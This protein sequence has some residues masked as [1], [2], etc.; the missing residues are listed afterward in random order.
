MGAIT[1][2]RMFGPCVVDGVSAGRL[3]SLPFERL[4]AELCQLAAQSAAAM[5][6]WLVLGAEIDR[7]TCRS[8]WGR[9]P[10][11]RGWRG[12]APWTLARP[13][14]MCGWRGRC[15]TCR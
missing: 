15:G 8:S 13:A 2:E 4:E 1:W 5:Y 9:R 6:R 11:P 3:E 10:P 12:G 7:R 14:S